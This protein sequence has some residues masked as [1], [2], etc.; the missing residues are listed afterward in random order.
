VA[1]LALFVAS[2]ESSFCTGAE[3]LIDGGL[4]AGV[5]NRTAQA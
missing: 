3:Y 4:P 1:N 2:D 5:V